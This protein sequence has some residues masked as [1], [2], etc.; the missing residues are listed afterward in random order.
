MPLRR[1]CRDGRRGRARPVNAPLGVLL[2]ARPVLARAV[3]PP[4]CRPAQ[5]R[6]C[7]GHGPGGLA[8]SVADAHRR[9]QGTGSNTN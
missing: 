3:R 6:F 7:P 8:G 9:R 4:G 5:T 1:G 2:I